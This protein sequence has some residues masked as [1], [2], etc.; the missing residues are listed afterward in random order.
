MNIKLNAITSE[1]E[2]N[3]NKEYIGEYKGRKYIGK[4]VPHTVANI[5]ELTGVNL[6]VDSTLFPNGIPFGSFVKVWE[7]ANA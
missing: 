4:F 1:T 6:N 5:P 2:V 7:V 3:P